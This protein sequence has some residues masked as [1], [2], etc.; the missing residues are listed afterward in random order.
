MHL[1][2][3]QACHKSGSVRYLERKEAM[4]I[5]PH[6]NLAFDLRGTEVGTFH[7]TPERIRDVAKD[8][9]IT[10]GPGSDETYMPT[11]LELEALTNMVTFAVDRGQ[12]F[13]FGYWPNEMIQLSSNRAGRLYTQDALGHPFS[14]PYIILHT[15]DDKQNE[16]SQKRVAELQGRNKAIPESSAYL[17]NPFP[18]T[19]K[20]CVDFE[21]LQFDAILIKGRQLLAVGDRGLF[22]G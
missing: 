10:S 21:I 12:V 7:L 22:L 14:T 4:E 18:V 13:D 3:M 11:S 1:A 2:V 8:Q 16:Q 6:G 19:D 20:L 15:W 17:V 9:R 5:T